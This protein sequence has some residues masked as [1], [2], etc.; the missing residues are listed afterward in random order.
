LLCKSNTDDLSG[1]IR[2]IKS[3]T[4]KQM[5]RYIQE[6]NE[7]RRT[8]MLNIFEF[9]AKKHKRNTQYQIWTH[10]NHAEYIYSNKF[11]R[12]KLD[13]V[14]N[15][16]VKRSHEALASNPVKAG[17]VENPEEYLYSSAGNYAGLDNLLLIEM[18]SLPWI[19]VS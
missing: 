14:H 2:D 5:L 9:E 18:L 10:K 11:I 17:I 19:T 8:W 15:N 16:L 3:F 1:T 4:S 13:Y 6:E 12:Q 7:S